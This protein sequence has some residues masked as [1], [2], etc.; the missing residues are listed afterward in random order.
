MICGP[1]NTQHRLN[2]RVLTTMRGSEDWD[3]FQSKS[4]RQR[5][6]NEDPMGDSVIA[7]I[8]LST[9]LFLGSSKRFEMT[10]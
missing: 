4:V 8:T 5:D 2:Y 3:L 1:P 9:R 7:E 6:S 10:E